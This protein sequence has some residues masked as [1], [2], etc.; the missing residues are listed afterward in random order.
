MRMDLS[1]IRMKL[2]FSKIGLLW[3]RGS[4]SVISVFILYV[5]PFERVDDFG[6]S[7]FKFSIDTNR[8]GQSGDETCNRVLHV[9]LYRTLTEVSR[10]NGCSWPKYV[11]RPT[12]E[13]VRI[14]FPLD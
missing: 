5:E 6:Q 14:T 1:N 13:F 7:H 11:C 9:I 3:S 4:G 8:F 10:R 2:N 12:T